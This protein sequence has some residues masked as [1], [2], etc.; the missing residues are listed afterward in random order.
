MRGNMKHHDDRRRRQAQAA[1]EACACVL[2][3]QFGARAVCV[4]GSLAG[5]SPWHGRSDI[6]LA[7]EGLA[8]ERYIAA[9]SALWQL[10]PERVEFDLITLEDAPPEPVARIKGE[11]KMPEDP[12]EALKIEIADELTNLSRIVDE[13]KQFL[14]KVSPEPTS[15]EVRAAGSLVHDFYTGIERIFERIAV[16]LGPGLPAGPGRHTLLLR[17]M[18]SE[19]EGKRPA[20]IDREPALRLVEYLGF[21]HVFRHS[22]GY[23]LLWRKL[24]PLIEGLRQTLAQLRQQLDRFTRSLIVY[25]RERRGR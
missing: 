7:V 20:V 24:R 3:E 25:R 21:R 5:E 1:A 15:F 9:L 17:S 6:D 22:Y 11:V 8:P 16:R 14:E 2:K 13:T 4:F 12:K 19:I 10:L 18:E 23:E